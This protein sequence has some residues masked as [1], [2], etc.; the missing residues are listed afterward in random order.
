MSRQR[1]R[2][3]TADCHT[4][5]LPSTSCRTII[6]LILPLTI[7]AVDATTNA[8]WPATMKRLQSTTLALVSL[9]AAARFAFHADVPTKA[10]ATSKI[11]AQA[12]IAT[13]TPSSSALFARFSW[14]NSKQHRSTTKSQLRTM[15]L[16]SNSKHSILL[17]SNYNL[18]SLIT[19]LRSFAWICFLR[20]SCDV[21]LTSQTFMNISLRQKRKNNFCFKSENFFVKQ[22]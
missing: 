2:A 12:P 18:L 5:R 1:R 17:I 11:V 8:A 20:K 16:H 4:F 19:L 9:I 3:L 15:N 21:N 14:T 10:K 7:H 22:E 13:H 6:Q